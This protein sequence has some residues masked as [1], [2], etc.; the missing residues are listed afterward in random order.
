MSLHMKLV[1]DLKTAIETEKV[2]NVSKQRQRLQQLR[3]QQIL[4]EQQDQQL[5]QPPL[6]QLQQQT[7]TISSQNNNNNESKG[8]LDLDNIEDTTQVCKLINSYI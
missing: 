4:L 6:I 1:A 8:L 2:I 3:Q 7:T 5:L